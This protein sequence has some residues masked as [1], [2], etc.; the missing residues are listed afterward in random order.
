MNTPG[1]IQGGFF[2]N[3]NA[4]IV[5]PESKVDLIRIIKET[6]SKKGSDCDLNFINISKLK[7]MSDLFAWSTF[8]GDISGWDV[9]NVKNM[10]GM[11]TN[12]KFNGDISKWDVSNV[13]DMSY[14]FTNSKFDGDIS[15]WN[16]SKVTD[17]R[18]MFEA[19]GLEK[20][21]KLPEWYK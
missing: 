11:F 5:T 15:K 21:N 16:V 9:S 10:A 13:E 7:D 12:S 1:S 14:M 18:D 3:V 4:R 6:I 20:L 8:V 2:N 19:S 17:M